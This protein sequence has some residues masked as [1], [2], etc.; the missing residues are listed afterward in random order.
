MPRWTVIE[1]IRSS[2]EK[3]MEMVRKRGMDVSIVHEAIDIDSKRREFMKEIEQLRKE[4]NLLS[5]EI[6]KSKDEST[7]KDLLQRAKSI[8]E[9]V[10]MK[11]REL[12][13]IESKWMETMKKL[14][15]IL[16]DDV[17]VGFSDEENVPVRFWGKPK[18][19]RESLEEFLNQTKRWGFEIEYELIENRKIVG[20]ADMLEKV[21]KM[22]DTLQA[23]KVA[24]S[25]FYYLIGDI[26]WLDFAISMYALDLL[27]R[28]GFIPVIPP[29]MLRTEVLEGAIDYSSFKDMIY[30][31]EGEDLNLIGT[32][33]H[34]LMALAFENPLKEQELP[35]KLVGWS[36]CFRKEAGAGNRDIKGIFR[37]HQFHKIEQF[38]FAHPENSW[39]HLDEMVENTEEILRG[40]ELPY[41]VVNVVSG[42]LGLP[43]AK[44]YDIEVWYPSQGKYREIASISQ[45]LD[46]Q[47]FRANLTYLRAADG[48]REY[49]HTLNGTG[50]PTSRAITAILENFQEADGR[51]IIPKVLRKYLEP[52]EKA[53]VDELRPKEK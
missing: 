14:P 32:A 27:T 8:E 20:H 10:A 33:E 34:P 35:L 21:L 53:P 4:H 9:K 16:A 6:S 48:R 40:L 24:G 26:V 17:P 7:R 38:I 36:P 52:I 49:L 31:I 1:V 25:R 41:R 18:V 23:A 46:W 3:Y 11:E 39:K 47:A 44:K 42:E 30:K 50:I 22:G 37:V 15:N 51:V 13:E 2:P 12:A 19:M 45:V 28:K 29:Y 43:A 5:R